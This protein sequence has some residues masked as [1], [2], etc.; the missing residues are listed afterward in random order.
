VKGIH[1]I[2]AAAAEAK[3]RGTQRVDDVMRSAKAA[4]PDTYDRSEEIVRKSVAASMGLV[5]GGQDKVE[6][7]YR[8]VEGT[9]P[10]AAAGSAVR[11]LG[12]RARQ[13]PLLT[14]PADALQE[15]NGVRML[16]ENA[17]ANP[18]CPMAHLWLGEALSALA[19]DQLVFNAARTVLNPLSALSRE[20]M[21]AVGR[22]GAG[23]DPAQQV[24]RRA[25]VLAVARLRKDKRDAVALHAIARIELANRRP[26]Q[27]VL[28]ARLAATAS[29]GAA[30][31]AAF[32]TL[33]RAYLSLG[34]DDRAR[35]SAM[36]AIDAGCTIGWD[37][38]AELLYRPG[39]GP[40]AN[41][42]GSRQRQYVDIKS[43]V[44]DEDRRLYCGVH[45]DAAEITRSVLKSQSAKAK[46][47]AAQL[48]KGISQ[49]GSRRRNK[50]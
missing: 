30:R 2:R 21:R 46:D 3:A 25:Y 41:Q 22:M 29:E 36:A 34:D 5:R 38:V 49:I 45:R 10:G 26:D 43:R 33:S 19:K 42:D 40:H 12:A 16:A 24:L 28:P 37:T 1:H 27:A 6:D 17:A 47:G 15:R 18:D 31:G 8:R 4:R 50:P 48:R 44:T 32:A 39:E 11:R 20:A 23:Q 14:L 7:G 9:A 35:R 13:I